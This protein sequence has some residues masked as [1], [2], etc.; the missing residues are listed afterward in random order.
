M[1][2][3]GI[4]GPRCARGHPFG[5][6]APT[7]GTLRAG[8][9]F[10][11]LLEQ[12]WQTGSASPPGGPG[13]GRRIFAPA[14]AWCLRPPQRLGR[15]PARSIQILWA[16]LQPRL[17]RR[18]RSRWT[19]I[20]GSGLAAGRRVSRLWRLAPESPPAGRGRGGGGRARVPGSGEGR[21]GGGYQLSLGRRGGGGAPPP[22][23]LPRSG[24]A[25]AG[26]LGTAPISFLPPPSPRSQ[27][28]EAAWR[29]GLPSLGSRSPGFRGRPDVG[30]TC[31]RRAPASLSP[32]W[33]C[34][35]PGAQVSGTGGC[36]GPRNRGLR[37]QE[38]QPQPLAP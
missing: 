10:H 9:G 8:G 7:F 21:G 35:P 14:R 15:G 33:L 18:G 24:G 31:G 2:R 5:P 38:A 13:R 12:A 20:P 19:R 36:L 3:R 32:L 23:Y 22:T 28:G 30:C 37:S 6:E 4:S 29:G 17:G 25:E 26:S 1:R 34:H 27:S 11:R 16:A